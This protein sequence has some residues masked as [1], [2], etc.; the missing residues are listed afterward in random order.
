[1][2]IVFGGSATGASAVDVEGT[3]G[4]DVLSGSAGNDT[5]DGLAGDDVIRGRAGLDRLLGGAGSDSIQGDRGPDS[6]DGGDG[7]DD[8]RGGFG[9][10]EI[11]ADGGDLV[12]GGGQNDRISA[13]NPFSLV[14]LHGGPGD[15]T[16]FAGLALNGPSPAPSRLHGESGDDFL[17]TSHE[18]ALAWGGRGADRIFSMAADTIR[19]GSGDDT[20]NVYVVCC[21]EDVVTV[22]GSARRILAGR[23]NGQVEVPAGGQLKVPALR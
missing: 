18:G 15:D 14:R 11:Q 12:F 1:M 6:L 21:H 7:A 19:G 2:L 9:R 5:I 23:V 8:V 13:L 17:F 4:P 3:D 20:I 16:L 10:D 22:H